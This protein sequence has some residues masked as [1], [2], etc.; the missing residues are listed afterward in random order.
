MI[1]TDAEAAEKLMKTACELIADPEKIAM[2]EKNVAKLALADAA[3]TIAEE[4]Y[5]I[6]K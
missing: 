4:V 5:K 1:V 3:M 2:M 6:I